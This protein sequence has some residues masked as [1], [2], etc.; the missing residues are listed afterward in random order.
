MSRSCLIYDVLNKVVIKGNLANTSVGEQNLFR[1]MYQQ[2]TQ[3]L[4]SDQ[5][6]ILW[7]MDRAY[8]SYDLCKTLSERGDVFV[9][10]YKKYFCK[11]VKAF[12]DSDKWKDRIM[13]SA[14]IWYNKKRQRKQSILAV[15]VLKIPLS[16]GETEYFITNLEYSAEELKRLYGMRWGVETCYDYLKNTLELENFSSKTVEGVLQ[17]YYASLLTCNLVN[18]LVEEA[19]QELNIQQVEKSNKYHYKINRVAAIGILRGEILKIL[20]TERNIPARLEQLKNQIKRNKNTVKPDHSFPRYKFKR[21]RRK[22]HPSKKKHCE[23]LKLT[24]LSISLRAIV[25]LMGLTRC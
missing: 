6:K 21:N 10:R 15:R 16:S 23:F 8:P 19:Q 14:T 2:A 1:E 22:Y 24:A 11:A 17:D 5:S 3:L 13:L 12:A 9:I 20:F 25:N 18:L 4:S 7:L